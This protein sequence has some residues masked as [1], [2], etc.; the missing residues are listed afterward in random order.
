MGRF[1]GRAEGAHVLLAVLSP[2]IPAELVNWAPWTRLR[3]RGLLNRS[4]SAARRLDELLQARL[5]SAPRLAR[6]PPPSERARLEPD[7]PREAREA[8]GVS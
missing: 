1:R 6:G 8:G 3:N 7:A 4:A 2:L 5:K